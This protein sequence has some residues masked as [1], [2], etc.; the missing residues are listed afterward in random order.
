MSDLQQRE[1]GTGVSEGVAYQSDAFAGTAYQRPRPKRHDAAIR[2]QAA[3]ALVPEIE[4][5]LGESISGPECEELV[6]TL[7]SCCGD[8]AYDIAREL[9][10]GGYTPDSS[11]VEVLDGFDTYRIHA[12]AVRLWIAETGATPKLSIGAT[13]AIPV[14]MAE[15]NG[16][17]G[18][19][20]AINER[21]GEYTVFCAAL[22]HVREGL[23]THG[24][25]FPWE[26]I[27]AATPAAP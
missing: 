2:R 15:H 7:S 8:D 11:L 4:E 13:V 17:V 1:A 14:K 5:W 20:I 23:G 22:G 6:R 3:E 18:E 9:E 10:R 25:I 24:L 21:H 12:D 19:I 16:V 26:E 27:E